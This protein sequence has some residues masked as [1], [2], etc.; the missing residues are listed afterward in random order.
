MKAN[1]F[2]NKNFTLKYRRLE[3]WMRKNDYSHAE[4]AA[5]LHISTEE[6]YHKLWQREYFAPEQINRLIVLLT[7]R[8]AIEVIFF[9]TMKEKIRVYKRV[10]EV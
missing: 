1:Y 7:A 2:Y 9:P 3:L 4:L 8:E 5:V 6:L 10:F